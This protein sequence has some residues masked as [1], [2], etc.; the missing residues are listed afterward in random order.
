M[1][2]RLFKSQEANPKRA[3]NEKQ[4]VD[5]SRTYNLWREPLKF[6]PERGAGNLEGR[7]IASA[8]NIISASQRNED[9]RVIIDRLAKLMYNVFC[10]MAKNDIP[11]NELEQKVFEY[12]AEKCSGVK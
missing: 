5:L 1:V 12:T 7:L 10:Y 2:W 8:T 11:L 3:E 6:A 9:K 4:T